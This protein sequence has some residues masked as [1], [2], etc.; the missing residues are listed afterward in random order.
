MIARHLPLIAACGSRAVKL[1]IVIVC[2]KVV[3]LTIDCL[4]SL[5]P[6]IA[7]VP[8]THV[9]VCENGTGG[10]AADRIRDAIAREGWGEWV[11]LTAIHPNRGFTGGNNAILRPALTSDDRPDY[12]YLLNADTIVRPGALRALVDFMDTNPQV[13]IAGSRLESLEGIPRSTAFRFFSVPGEFE[14]AIRLGPVSRLLRRWEGTGPL[15]TVPTPTDWTSGAALLVR[16]QVFEEIGL[17]DEDLYTYFDDIDLCLRARR[18]GWPTWVVPDSHVVHLMGQSTGVTQ[19]D[20]RPKRRPTYWFQ[21]RRHFWLKNYG[22]LTTAAADAAWISGY[23]LWRLR[24]FIQRLPDNDPPHLLSDALRHS[25]FVTGFR[26][27]P[28]PNPALT[29]V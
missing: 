19:R 22:P 27:R 24:R 21:A 18:A 10:D 16:R 3:D 8:G 26:K 6:E 25:V 28:V 23:A 12:C 11:T 2:Y 5:A 14:R 1:L 7:T 9:A 29:G 20:T 4:R 15:P 17:L 13:G